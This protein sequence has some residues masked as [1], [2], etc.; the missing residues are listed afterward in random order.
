MSRAGS[1]YDRLARWYRALELA[2]FGRDLERARFAFLGQLGECG[3]ILLLGEGD[4]RC[5]QRLALIAPRSRIHCVDS[6]PG[7]IEWATRRIAAT[8][9]GSRVTFERADLRTF[10]PDPGSFDAVATLF[11][12]DCFDAQGVESL[13]S[14]V[15]PGLRR[16]ARWL[17]ADFVL[18]PGALA[19]A[20]ARAWLAVL[21]AYF[22]WETG[23]RVSALPP[24]EAILERA[25]WRRTAFLDLNRGFVRSAVFERA[26]EQP[27]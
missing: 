16:R 5:A 27:T 4:G 12:L 8:G 14:R 6:S 22:R 13:V 17:F 10:V 1:S 11:V 18:P 21:Y 25:G 7:M 23:L 24:S 26:Q 19:R 3:S 2:A 9:A 15:S 20:R